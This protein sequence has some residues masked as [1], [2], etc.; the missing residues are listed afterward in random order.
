MEIFLKIRYYK[1]CYNRIDIREGNDL[2]KRSSSEE[3]M[4][5][6]NAMYAMVVM[7]IASVSNVAIITVKNVDYRCMIHSIRKSETIDLL[8]NSVLK[9]FGYIYKNIDVGTVMKNSELLKFIP[10][11]LKIKKMCKHAVKKL[12]N[13]LLVFP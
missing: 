12:P 8:K 6:Y 1:C 9:N 5:C 13:P 4:I 10:D 11:H 2:A 3:C 7:L